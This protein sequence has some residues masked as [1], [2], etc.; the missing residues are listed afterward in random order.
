MI[1]RKQTSLIRRRLAKFS[2]VAILGPRQCGKTTLARQ[3]GGR[4]FDLEQQGIQVLLDAQ[5][6]E[7]VAGQD[8]VVLDEA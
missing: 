3:L 4:Y 5:W 7:L 6:D 8:L 1:P 2:A